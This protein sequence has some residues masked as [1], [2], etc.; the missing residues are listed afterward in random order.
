MR[1][2]WYVIKNEVVVATVPDG[3]TAELIAKGKKADYI[4]D[5]ID[6]IPDPD[7]KHKIYINHN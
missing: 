6:G 2:S 5:E 4:T 1:K 3:R 7:C